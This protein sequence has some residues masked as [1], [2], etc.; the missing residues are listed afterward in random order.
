MR[1]F[2]EFDDY[3]KLYDFMVDTQYNGWIKNRSIEDYFAIHLKT[4]KDVDID[5][6]EM[7]NLSATLF[8]TGQILD[9][10]SDRSHIIVS[11]SYDKD[12][13]NEVVDKFIEDRRGKLVKFMVIMKFLENNFDFTIDYNSFIP[14]RNEHS[15]MFDIFFPADRSK[16]FHILENLFKIL[17]NC[18]TEDFIVKISDQ[19]LAQV[20]NDLKSL[21]ITNKKPFQSFA[22]G[23]LLNLNQ[24][25]MHY[26][27]GT[28]SHLPM[29][30][31]HTA[32]DRFDNEIELFAYLKE[33][34]KM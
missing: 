3:K 5:E 14:S 27:Y 6:E 10:S 30:F 33:S 8:V 31:K 32:K 4:F 18:E 28:K 25:S 26:S 15:L 21:S 13:I 29:I 16:F 11:K 12:K 17:N 19:V 9:P 34:R 1:S 22:I 20:R 7:K 23:S 24:F 2:E